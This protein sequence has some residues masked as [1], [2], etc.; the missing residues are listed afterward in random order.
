RFFRSHHK[1]DRCMKFS[2]RA[3]TVRPRAVWMFVGAVVLGMAF[4]A[5]QRT[6]EAWHSL[7]QE[8]KSGLVWPEPAVVTPGATVG[9]PP[10]DAIVLFDGQDMSAWHG[11]EKWKIEDGAATVTGGVTTKQKFG[12][13]QLHLEFASPEK[14]SGRGQGR[15]NS[16]V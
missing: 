16:G 7:L 8:W 11:G 13:C 5:G 10:S 2:I 1:E 15:G 3:V 12:D 9:E 6:T 14:V 4:F